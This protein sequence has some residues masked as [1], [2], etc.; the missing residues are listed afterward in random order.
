MKKVIIQFG[1]EKHEVV[2]SSGA[3]VGQC[4]TDMT[5]KVVLGYGDNVR[6]LVGGV[7]QSLDAIPSDGS[8]I[9]LEQRANQKAI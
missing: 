6:P 3:N 5:A 1:C 4:I 7:E 2:I 8:V 9:T